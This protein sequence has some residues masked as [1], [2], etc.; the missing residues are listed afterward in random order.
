M[1]DSNRRQC[2]YERIS[3]ASLTMSMEIVRTICVMGW[4]IGLYS[5]QMELACD[6]QSDYYAVPECVSRYFLDLGRS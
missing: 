3:L 5:P 4:G 2:C 1:W 6:L